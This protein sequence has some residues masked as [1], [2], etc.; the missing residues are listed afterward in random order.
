MSSIQGSSA[1]LP[2]GANGWGSERLSWGA[3]GCDFDHSRSTFICFLIRYISCSQPPPQK[4][5]LSK[6]SPSKESGVGEREGM[7]EKEKA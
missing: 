7:K 2:R 1:L 4:K 3:L 5:V 6:S